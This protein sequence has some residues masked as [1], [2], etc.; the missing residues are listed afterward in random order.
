MTRHTN[1][2]RVAVGAA[3]LVWLAVGACSFGP[4]ADT[5]SF[6]VLTSLDEMKGES[7]GMTGSSL[8]IGIGPVGFPHYL[9]RNGLVTRVSDN[10][11]DIS[12]VER[13]A[14]P[15]P[16]S[17]TETLGENLSVLL[18]TERIYAYPW[19]SSDPLDYTVEMYV[20]RFE[21][22]TL[23][24]VRFMSRWT[25][26]DAESGNELVR[27]ETTLEEPA[28][29][30]ETSA[31]VEAQSRVLAALSREIADAILRQPRQEPSPS[32]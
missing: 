16:E 7:L 13:W 31:S 3:A 5:S 19:H 14:E 32:G 17:V 24:V 6:Y 21:R 12:D 28:G 26:R 10:Q 11:V 2:A 30:A 1:T 29:S 25:L 4:Q 20:Y 27:R 22:D 18:G 23:G 15:L 9:N 8:G